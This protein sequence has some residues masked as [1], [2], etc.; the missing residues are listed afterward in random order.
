MAVPRDRPT[1]D[2]ES[3]LSNACPKPPRRP[4]DPSIARAVA[5]S[6]GVAGAAPLRHGVR[7]AGPGVPLPVGELRLDRTA[8]LVSILSG[9]PLERLAGRPVGLAGGQCGH[10][11]GGV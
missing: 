9:A 4:Y 7:S 6:T 3:P 10:H 5:A 1:L 2:D 8:H 11:G